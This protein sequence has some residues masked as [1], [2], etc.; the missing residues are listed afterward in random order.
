MLKRITK[1][2]FEQLVRNKRNVKLVSLCCGQDTQKT[3]PASFPVS[4]QD[5]EQKADLYLEK[6]DLLI[7]YH[8]ANNRK[9]IDVA[10]SK[11][12]DLGYKK[13]VHYIGESEEINTAF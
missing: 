4:L 9:V 2:Q 7:I 11:L 5:I 8:Y 6:S 10:V 1:S 3:I 13:I 12:T